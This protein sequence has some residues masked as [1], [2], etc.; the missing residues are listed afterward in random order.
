MHSIYEYDQSI[1]NEVTWRNKGIY[2]CVRESTSKRKEEID[3]VGEIVGWMEID[4]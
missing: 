1:D 3:R 2:V 4:I